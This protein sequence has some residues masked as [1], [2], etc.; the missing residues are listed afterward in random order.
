MIE[1]K[2]V[3]S[4]AQAHISSR[5]LVRPTHLGLLGNSCV[6]VM[7][8]HPGPSRSCAYSMFESNFRNTTGRKTRAFCRWSD[9][10]GL[11]LKVLD[12]KNKIGAT[13]LKLRTE[14]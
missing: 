12:A 9:V 5:Q 4:C 1:E 14:Y 6:A 8:D 2:L 10:G 11:L 7:I 13:K 3:A